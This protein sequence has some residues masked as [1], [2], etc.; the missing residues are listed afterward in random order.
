MK[1]ISLSMDAFLWWNLLFHHKETYI[2]LGND[3]TNFIKFI[4]EVSL[5]K[6]WHL[7]WW[8]R[9][10]VDVRIST[11]DINVHNKYKKKIWY[12]H[13]NEIQEVCKLIAFCRLIHNILSIYVWIFHLV[14][15]HLLLHYCLYIALPQK[16]FIVAGRMASSGAGAPPVPVSRS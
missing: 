10:V 9:F 8:K 15:T 2:T 16:T 1:T 13:S 11:S 14:S 5:W 3:E 6:F 7:P 12:N 4:T